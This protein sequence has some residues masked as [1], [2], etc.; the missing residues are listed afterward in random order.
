MEETCAPRPCLSFGGTADPLAGPPE[1]MP[2][3]EDGGAIPNE[4]AI[5]GA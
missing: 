2:H 1:G 5:L 3:P 4:F